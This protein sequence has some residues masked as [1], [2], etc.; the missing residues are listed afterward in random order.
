MTS[1]LSTSTLSSSLYLLLLPEW[2]H[3]LPCSGT[4]YHCLNLLL[5]AAKDLLLLLALLF[6]RRQLSLL[7]QDLLLLQRKLLS[8]GLVCGRR[9][10]TP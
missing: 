2:M 1:S 7:L 3:R 5:L 8:Q 4:S 10:P 6:V 9:I